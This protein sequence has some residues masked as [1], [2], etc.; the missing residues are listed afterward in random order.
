LFF[1]DKTPH[2]IIIINDEFP[3]VRGHDA[4]RRRRRISAAKGHNLFFF[5]LV[6]G[7]KRNFTSRFC[8]T[9]STTNKDE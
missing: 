8:A 6:G 2:Q 1:W 7:G 9:K 4:R 3:V 5:S